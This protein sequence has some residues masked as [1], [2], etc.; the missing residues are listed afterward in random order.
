MLTPDQ[1]QKEWEMFKFYIK[2][3]IAEPR[4]SKLIEFYTKYEDRIKHIPASFN[5][6]QHSAFNGGYLY[7]T[8]NVVKNSLLL[9]EL[10]DIAGVNRNYTEEE[11]VFSAINH[12]LG[13]MG[14]HEYIGCLHNPSEWHKTNLGEMY[15]INPEMEFMT[16]SDRGL[17]M[18]QYHDIPITRNEWI[19]IKTHDGLYN[20]A[21]KP[22]LFNKPKSAISLI[23]HQADLMA[24][25]IEYEQQYLNTP[26]L[27]K[28]TTNNKKQIRP[29][30]FELINNLDKN[31]GLINALD[32]L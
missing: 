4:T 19:V 12:D 3:Y 16:I 22:Y 14:D 32:K 13:K 1:I 7:H 31:N 20:E 21:N 5:T 11:L 15:I 30:A 10:W 2:E 17:F 25:R 9:H 29:K 18:L 8:N 24:A 6:K 28:P 23:L 26:K 27:E